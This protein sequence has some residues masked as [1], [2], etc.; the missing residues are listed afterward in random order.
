MIRDREDVVS[1][2]FT[3]SGVLILGTFRPLCTAVTSGTQLMAYA[4]YEL[5]QDD[6]KGGR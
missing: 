1:A 6:E 4:N 2:P 3:G 5:N